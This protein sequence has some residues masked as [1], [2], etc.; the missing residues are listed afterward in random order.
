M[1]GLISQVKALQEETSEMKALLLKM[2]VKIQE[3]E[4]KIA[5]LEKENDVFKEFCKKQK[6]KKKKAIK[7]R[8]LSEVMMK[9]EEQTSKKT[10]KAKTRSSKST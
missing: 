5:V 4:T 8:R 2:Q 6:K 1:S 9:E 7:K 10:C 3:E